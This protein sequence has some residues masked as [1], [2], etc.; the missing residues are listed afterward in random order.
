VLLVF[1][2]SLHI[3]DPAFCILLL[4]GEKGICWR[5]NS[6]A[7]LGS[8]L[9]PW[10]QFTLGAWTKAS[11]KHWQK[12]KSQTKNPYKRLSEIERHTTILIKK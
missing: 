2:G 5:L 9:S 4:I 8:I 11:V 7:D 12:K 3:L 6:T 1:Q 10:Q